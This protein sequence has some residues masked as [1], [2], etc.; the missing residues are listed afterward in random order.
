MMRTVQALGTLAIACMATQASAENTDKKEPGAPQTEL[1]FTETVLLG[2]AID[3]GQTPKGGRTIIPITGGTFAGPDMRGQVMPG[4]WDWQ[5]HLANGCT[6]VEADYFLKTD[7]DAIINIVNKGTLC[8][9]ET[10]AEESGFAF[11]AFTQPVLEAPLGK[12]EWVNGASFVGT[13]QPGQGP[14]GEPAVIIG[15]YKVK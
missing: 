3:A 7:D 9:P 11:L 12:Y 5:L 8:P 4:G 14:E 6:L 15:V 13:L 1:V 2:E 10:P